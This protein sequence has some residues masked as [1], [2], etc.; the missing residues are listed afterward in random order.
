M[1]HREQ[2]RCSTHGS[3]WSTQ[4]CCRVGAQAT[5]THLIDYTMVLVL[6][7]R[8]KS[9][10]YR[11]LWKA[12]TCL[13]LDLTPSFCLLFSPSINSHWPQNPWW[14]H[15][16]AVFLLVWPMLW[17]CSRTRAWLNW[18]WCN[19]TCLSHDYIK[20]KQFFDLRFSKNLLPKLRPFL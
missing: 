14:S 7:L 5:V 3:R 10:L 4:R 13:T 8:S 9:D 17:K 16:A 6:H 19:F 18:L 11:E 20:S 1:Q 2:S 12:A 15:H